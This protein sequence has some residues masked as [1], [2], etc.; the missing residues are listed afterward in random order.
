MQSLSGNQAGQVT[1][2][3]PGQ[4]RHFDFIRQGPPGELLAVVIA[5]ELVSIIIWA[6]IVLVGLLMLK[7]SGFQRVLIIL[8]GALAGGVTHLY[9]PLLIERILAI[10]AYPAGLVLLLWLA[11]WIYIRLPELRRT[12]ASKRQRALQD[13]RRV[14]LRTKKKDSAPESPAE[15]EVKPSEHE[16]E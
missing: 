5:K 2:K 12:W 16:E 14:P 9:S 10:G 15:N 1:F 11:Q 8:T 4:G 6:P 13:K 3:L 7:L